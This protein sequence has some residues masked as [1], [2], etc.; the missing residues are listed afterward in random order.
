MR[1]TMCIQQD[2]A[3]VV[4]YG[5]SV[6]FTNIMLCLSIGGLRELKISPASKRKEAFST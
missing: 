5:L 3:S 4:N 6:A 1:L 2:Q